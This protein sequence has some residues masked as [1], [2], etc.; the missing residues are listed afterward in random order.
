[1]PK[2][3]VFLIDCF[4]AGW[5]LMQDC[6]HGCDWYGCANK[7]SDPPGKIT[8]GMTGEVLEIVHHVVEIDMEIEVIREPQQPAIKPCDSF[9]C[10]QRGIHE[11]W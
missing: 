1:M 2:L 11:R 6:R 3:D 7:D 9:G 5:M 4:K 8:C 10:M